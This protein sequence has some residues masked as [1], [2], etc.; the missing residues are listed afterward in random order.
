VFA[1]ACR[2]GAEASFPR[3][4]TVPIAPARVPSG[5]RFAIPPASPC[6]GSEARFGIGN[7]AVANMMRRAATDAGAHRS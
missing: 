1:H 3:G 4:W 2:L 6:S 5:S 7:K